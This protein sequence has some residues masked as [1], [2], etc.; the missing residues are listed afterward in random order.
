MDTKDDFIWCQRLV[1]EALLELDHHGK[2]PVHINIP[3]N[4]YNVSFT[5]KELP[6]VTKFERLQYAYEQEKW[7]DRVEKL[8]RCKKF[9]LFADRIV[10]YLKN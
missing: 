9:C 2:G 10:M 6:E 8:K 7:D 1:N 4:S 5:V 3:M